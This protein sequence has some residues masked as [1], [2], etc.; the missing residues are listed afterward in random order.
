[1]RYAGKVKIGN[2]KAM[3]VP[4]KF[5]SKNLHHTILTESSFAVKNKIKK[6]MTKLSIKTYS[7]TI[8][9]TAIIQTNK[10]WIS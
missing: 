9:T 6:F 1:M 8:S 10:Q 7:T 4:K 2:K 3:A 5:E